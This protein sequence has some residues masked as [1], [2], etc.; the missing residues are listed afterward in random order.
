M[1]NKSDIFKTIFD[2]SEVLRDSFGHHQMIQ[3]V[4][5]KLTEDLDLRRATIM[6]LDEDAERLYVEANT[7]ELNQDTSY[8]RGEGIIGTVLQ[9]GRPAVIPCIADEPKFSGRLYGKRSDA[10]LDLS[11]ICVPIQISRETIGTF[12]AEVK[13]DSLADLTDIQRLFAIVASMIANDVKNRR[14]AR[15]ERR[16]LTEENIRLRSELDKNFKPGN[17][18]GNSN[19]MRDVYQKITQ[20]APSNTTILIRGESGTGKELVA[21]AIHYNSTRSG[22]PF[23]KINCAALNEN[24]LE[25]ELFGHEKGAFTGA[26]NKRIGKFEEADGGTIFLDEMGEF[27][28]NVQVK[29]LRVL[30]EREIERVGSNK[31]LKVDVRIIAATNRDLEQSVERGDFRQDLYYRINVFPVYL[32]P[33]RERRD[34]ILLLADHFSEACAEKMGKRIRRITTNAINMLLAYHW[35]GNIREL[36]NAIE[37][38]VILSDDGIIHGYHLPPSLQ[39]PLT[40]VQKP[41]GTLKMRVKMLEKDVIIDSLKRNNGKVNQSSK[42]LGISSRMLRYKIDDLDIDYKKFFS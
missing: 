12:S 37:H 10:E 3:D 31:T 40:G 17:M 34:D 23:V 19:A 32:P 39:V 5:N 7:D 15:I 24:L 16:A 30:Q 35:P 18:L 22:K 38:A 41:I 11:F 33:L 2:V 20:A 28:H 29:L 27:S 21:S 9:S 1:S 42:E 36:E 26:T 25:S 13:C 4:L 8:K 14:M 6:L